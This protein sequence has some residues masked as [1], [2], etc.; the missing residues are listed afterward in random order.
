LQAVDGKPEGFQYALL[1]G[2]KVSKINPSHKE[3]EAEITT[4]SDLSAFSFEV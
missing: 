1:S 3:N 2:L 4:S